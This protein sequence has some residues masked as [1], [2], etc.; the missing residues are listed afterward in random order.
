[1][2]APKKMLLLSFVLSIPLFLGMVAGS[3]AKDEVCVACHRGVTPL[4]VEDW[5]MSKHSENDVTCST[6]HGSEH[7]SKKT[8]DLVKMPDESICAEC[9]EEQVEQFKKG[10]H[11][12]GWS[13]MKALPVTALEPE[14]LI[15]GGKGCGGCHNMGVKTEEQKKELRGKGYIYNNSSCD[16][17][18][19]RHTFSKKEAQEP[20]TCARCHLGFDH[21]QW[22]MYET[23]KHGT[24]Y[25]AREGG[26]LPQEAPAPT[27]QFCHL[28]DG[29]HANKVAW[30]FLAVRLPMP[31]DKQWAE[32]RGVILKA[33][34]VLGPEG[35]PTGR[36]E[37]V[38]TLDLARLTQEDWET[39]REGMIKICA[40]C[41]SEKFARG[42]L[43][44]GDRM[45]QKA[46]RLMAEA[47]TVVA[48]LYTEGIL[49]KPETYAYAHPDL[50]HF[51]RTGGS[52][53]EQV[54]CQMFMKH[55][56][57]TYQGMFHANPD[58]AYWYGWSALLKDLDEIKE[59]AAFLRLK[60]KAG[61]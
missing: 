3:P 17:C 51:Y 53:I 40:K 35:N 28:P 42:E 60:E 46:D 41:H 25:H 31:E 22:E 21:P 2:S 37:A 11:S 56:M 12:L 1:M 38:K 48:D 43:E 26:R 61:K 18:H 15:D 8:V 27:C 14:E 52:H 45:I 4:Q 36:L 19:T 54:L 49:K 6:C 24:R 10:K 58:Y 50:L 9:H 23:S 32:D 57:R 39:E 44:K 59:E 13:S 34:G 55:R 16:E 5:K 30:G 7:K 20:K 33:L 29:T 47:I